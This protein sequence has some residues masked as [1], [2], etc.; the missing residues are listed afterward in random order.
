MRSGRWQSMTALAVRMRPH[1]M[2]SPANRGYDVDAMLGRLLHY[3]FFAAVF[4]PYIRIAPLGS[5]V[6][7]TAVIL[8]AIVIL[9]STSGRFPRAIVP[10]FVVMVSAG[11]IAVATGLNALTIRGLA[12]YFSLFI[13]SFA[14]YSALKAEGGLSRRFI[15]TTIGIW[16][17]VGFV[18]VAIRHDFLTILLSNA[19]TTANR[20]VVGLAPEP[21]S[22]GIH[23][24]ILL[25]L[26]NELFG[27]REKRLLGAALL[28][29]VLL[30]ARS[31]MAVLFLLIWGV[32]YL[33]TRAGV[34][35][36]MI[37][38]LA[39]G[40]VAVGAFEL[41]ARLAERIKGVRI[42]DLVRL[43]ATAPALILVRDQ[44]ISDRVAGI[45]FSFAGAFDGWLLPHGFTSWT[46]WVQEIGPRMIRYI[47][48]YTAGDRIMSGYGAAVYE[49]GFIGL[50]IPY[51]VTHAASLHYGTDRRRFVTVAVVLNLL[52]L[53]A[54]P[55]AYPPVG[56]LIG[57]FCYYANPVPGPEVVANRSLVAES[58]LLPI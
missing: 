29:Q 50:L 32:A 33:A 23:C 24:L 8:G 11:L 1:N 51:V 38:G 36:S 14:A 21:T 58:P 18:Q 17:T 34:I 16:F 52:F 22:Y 55:L 57:Y 28:V 9:S 43:V 27:G 6:Q 4:F 2:A 26:V 30:F 46:R 40:I 5:D 41:L 35:R 54:L 7:P 13:I 39:L 48:Y 45:T 20:G 25:L 31:S 19:R 10:L 3:A 15:A 47:P 12:N 56:F 44:S 53:T 37:G 49:L 42:F